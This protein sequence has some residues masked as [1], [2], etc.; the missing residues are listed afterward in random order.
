MGLKLFQL[1]IVVTLPRWSST[2]EHNRLGLSWEFRVL[3]SKSLINILEK[4][5]NCLSKICL[6]S[7]SWDGWMVRWGIIWKLD[8][9]VHICM[10]DNM[11]LWTYSGFTVIY[12]PC[13]PTD[14]LDWEAK[15]LPMAEGRSEWRE[16]GDPHVRQDP[17]L[18]Q[19]M[20]SH[21]LVH[22]SVVDI[23]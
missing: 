9:R 8:D 22:T 17:H 1:S 16:T 19:Q 2:A 7:S 13:T 21:I 10:A 14:G 23:L 11:L 4:R 6:H 15:D 18:Q 5:I 12:G 3:E 20:D